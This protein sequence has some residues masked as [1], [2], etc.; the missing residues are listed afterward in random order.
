MV[1][2]RDMVFPYVNMVSYW[3][4]LFAVLLLVAISSC[5]AEPPAQ[6]GLCTTAGN[7]RGLRGQPG[8]HF[9][10]RFPGVLHHRIHDGRFELRGDGVGAHARDDA[11]ADASDDMGHFHGD[12]PGAAG[13]SGP[14]RQRHHD[15]P[16]PDAGHEFLYARYR[17]RASISSQRRQPADVSTPVLV[18]RS[19]GVHRRAPGLWH[20]LRSAQCPREKKHLRLPD[21]GV[22]HSGDR[23]TQ[24]H[25][26][27][28]PYVTSAE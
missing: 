13:L 25:R 12:H 4:Y 10:A 9:D 16:G 15:D 22:G 26:V 11:D 7:P 17:L 19:R 27:G 18:L 14:V 24:F 8:H 2:A 6:A 3:V 1:G 20:R 28:A 21:D 23:W 5:P